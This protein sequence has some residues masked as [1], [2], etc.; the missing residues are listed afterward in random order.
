[1]SSQGVYHRVGDLITERDDGCIRRGKNQLS[2][3]VLSQRIFNPTPWD[4]PHRTLRDLIFPHGRPETVQTVDLGTAEIHAGEKKKMPMAEPG[5]MLPREITAQFVIAAHCIRIQLTHA[6][7]QKHKRH[8]VGSHVF[9]IMPLPEAREIENPVDGQGDRRVDQLLGKFVLQLHAENHQRISLRTKFP[10]HAV[11]E[12]TV[13]LIMQVVDND[14]D[15]A[16]ATGAQRRGHGVRN[17]PHAVRSFP[18]QT[19]RGVRETSVIP[20]GA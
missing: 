11:D 10:V 13:V 9:D 18:D 20:Q 14:R 17:I 7:V 8:S 5:Q 1:M 6:P 12:V 4:H 2:Q 3:T 16:A 19:A 15:H